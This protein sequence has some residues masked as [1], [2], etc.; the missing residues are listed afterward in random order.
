MKRILLA[1]LPVLFHCLLIS[2]P[3]VYIDANFRE[4]IQADGSWVDYNKDGWLDVFYTGDKYS[5]DVQIVLTELERNMKN[6]DFQRISNGIRDVYLAGIDWGDY[7]RDGDEDLL[8]CGETKEGTLFTGIYK[9]HRNGSFSLQN[10]KLTPVRDGSVE[11]GDFDN[12]GDLDILLTGETN[13]K[14]IV[15][16]IYENLG[17]NRFVDFEAGITPV[18]YGTGKWGDYDKDGDL[19]VLLVGEGYKGRIVGE[20]Y[21]NEGPKGFVKIQQQ[22][23]PVRFADASWGDLDNDGD[24][25]IILSGETYAGGITAGVFK[26]N[27]NGTFT[28][29][30]TEITG[31]RSGNLDLGDYDNDGDLDLVITG[32]TYGP[33]VTNIYRNDS[34]FVFTDVHADLPGVS[35]GG[36]YWGNYDRDDDLDILLLGL[37]NCYD[38]TAKLYRND[39]DYKPKVVEEDLTDGRSLWTTTP[40]NIVIPPYHYFVYSSCYCDPF[41]EGGK[42]FHAFVSNIHYAKRKYELMERYNEIIMKNVVTWPKVDAGHRISI[43]FVTKAEAQEGRRKVI[44][45]YEDEGFIIHYVQW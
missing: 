6:G 33:S 17:N 32:E 13:R 23:I 44:R 35:L 28:E 16:I 14:K 5:G 30:I 9:N 8:L 22:L 41:N 45:E 42:K 19:D 27:G 7:D 10:I 4:V 36:A 40:M 15:S 18:F 11:W 38:F 29:M 31:T 2:Q 39:G 3:F 34:N 43:G 25:D 12:D 1:I 37:D 20:I 21:R 26:N 24:L